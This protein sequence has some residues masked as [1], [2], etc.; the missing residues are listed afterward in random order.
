MK[1]LCL[2]GKKREARYVPPQG[3]QPLLVGKEIGELIVR[4]T[5]TTNLV[6]VE[7]EDTLSH[8]A[9][10]LRQ[11]QFHH[12][13]VV[14]AVPT[15]GAQDNPSTTHKTLYFEGVLTSQDIE[16]AAALVP[17]E[18]SNELLHRP[19]QELRVAEV[20][21]PSPLSITPLTSVVAAAQLLVER[22]LQY[23]PVVEYRQSGEETRLI[24]VGLLTRSDLLMAFARTMGASE[25]GVNVHIPFTAG[26]MTPVAQ[27]LLLAAELQIPVQTVFADHPA[28]GAVPT[29][30]IRLGTI[31]P[32]PFLARLKK[33]HIQYTFA[34]MA[35]KDDALV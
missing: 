33:D 20:M 11:H 21:R 5:M 29:A 9:Q 23:L 15:A 28:Q 4:D 14:R 34:E 7:P 6:T 32:A 22:G 26:N 35:R 31:H 19:W 17:H 10:L 24:L 2:R 8:A 12:L 27:A 3:G 18:S 1:K 13:P 16:M 30:T 25:P